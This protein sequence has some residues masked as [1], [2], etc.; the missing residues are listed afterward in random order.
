MR[1]VER[2]DKY[3]ITGGTGS[4]GHVVVKRLLSG[5]SA[6]IIIFSRDE[7]KQELFRNQYNNPRLKFVI[8]DIRDKE[9][10][11]RAIEQSQP[12]YIFHAAALKQ[13]PAA[14]IYPMEYI[15]TNVLGSE[16]V[17]SSAVEHGVKRV[18]ILS[19]DK[20]VMPINTMGMTKALMEKLMVNYSQRSRFTKFCGV[21][22]GNVLYSRGSVVPY[23]VSLIKSNQRLRV[24][25]PNMTRFLLTLDD[26]VDLVLETLINGE[27][28]KMYIKRAPACTISNLALA[29]NKIFGIEDGYEIVGMRTGEKIHETLEAN[30]GEEP[31]TSENTRQLSVEEVKELLLT[32]PEIQK[33]LQIIAQESRN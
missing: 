6:D 23:F 2:P 20:A 18:V 24:T 14:E 12:D 32:L 19:T 13:V 8:G 1:L 33:E 15:K 10:I 26:A 31:F 27:N 4:F 28:G 29:I 30:E 21:R 17:F 7:L 16:N 3:F 9:S 25:N 5:S 22:Y 11:D